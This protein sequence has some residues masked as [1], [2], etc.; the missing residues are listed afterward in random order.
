M[1]YR[2]FGKLDWQPS[3]LGFGVMRMPVIDGDSAKIEEVEATQMIRHA[4]D[5]GVNYIDTAYPYHQQQSEKFL[6]RALAD[7]YRERVKLASKLPCWLVKTADDFDRL[8]NEQLERLKTD[9]IDFYLLHALNKD[10]WPKMRDLGVLK[11]AEGAI[12]DGR[13]KHL[14]FSFHDSVEVFE[15]IVDAYDKWTFCQIQYNYMDEEH[16]AG[17]RGLKYAAEKGLAVVV[18][19]PIRGGK[20][21]GPVP[22]AVQTLWDTAPTQRGPVDWALQWVWNQPEVSLLLSGMSNMEQVEQNLVSAEN[23]S[24]GILNAEELALVSQVQETYTKLSPIGCTDC[25]YCLPCPSGVDIPRNLN[26]YN[27]AFMYGLEHGKGGYQWIP[28]DQRA[29]VCIQCGECETACPQDLPIIEW[30]EKVDQLMTA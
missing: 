11:W 19:E 26:T 1:Q 28:D 12:A 23:S 10:S 8:L 4:I 13:I 2:K 7:G 30:L 21:A 17:L 5:Q 24:I 14:G 29:D 6:G 27:E 20:L 3:A 15:E 16:Q 9:T 18:M 25:K 22:D